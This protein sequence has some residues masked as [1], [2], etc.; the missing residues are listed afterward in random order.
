MKINIKSITGNILNLEVDKAD[1]IKSVKQQIKDKQGIPINEQLLTFHLLSLK[2]DCTLYD[3]NIQNGDTLEYIHVSDGNINIYIKRPRTITLY[4]HVNIT[5]TIESV[6]E[7]IQEK[8]GAPV[9][10]Q[11]LF[12][13]GLLLQ[14]SHTL[15]HY[16]ITNES[17]LDFV[18]NDRGYV[19]IY[20][21][22][23]GK[24]ILTL[25]A[26]FSDSIE[27]LKQKIENK[28]GIPINQQYLTFK[29]IYLEDSY[30]LDDYDILGESCIDLVNLI[31]GN[32]TINIHR[33]GEDVLT[34]NVSN[35]DSVISVKQRIQ[36]KKDIPINQQHLIFQGIYLEDDYI[37]NDLNIKNES[38]L[39]LALSLHV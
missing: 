1:T 3:Y 39:D 6:K 27:S 22:D 32:M 38:D 10:E 35:T 13:K 30:I 29:G 18:M 5:N 16:N 26:T 15:Q 7:I 4:L 31:D 24:K 9:L 19:K 23:N 25:D 2:D 12:F 11:D 8:F 37:L 17:T 14:D 36:K 20:I 34:L 21:R 28:K 33:Y